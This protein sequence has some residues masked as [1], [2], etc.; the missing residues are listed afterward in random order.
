MRS[1]QRDDS[2]DAHASQTPADPPVREAQGEAQVSLPHLS[3][4]GVHMPRGRVPGSPAHVLHLQRLRQAQ[5]Y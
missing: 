5:G 3:R 2:L 4:H 1:L